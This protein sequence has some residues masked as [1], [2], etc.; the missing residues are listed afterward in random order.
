MNPAG[1]TFFRTVTMDLE[2]S[3][4]RPIV[5]ILGKAHE[6]FGGTKQNFLFSFKDI[7]PSLI[8]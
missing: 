3:K 8:T 5:S 6:L 7:H 2:S 1:R 4:R